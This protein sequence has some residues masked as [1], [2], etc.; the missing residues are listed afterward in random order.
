DA[1]RYAVAASAPNGTLTV[2]AMYFG[3]TIPFPLES[4]YAK[5]INLRTGRIHARATFPDPLAY[6]AKGHFHAEAVT[7]RIVPFSQAAE[8]YLDPS[9]KIVLRNDWP[10]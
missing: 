2:V 3:D 5:I 6:C 10:S 4:V 1:L 9:A 7:S 8:A